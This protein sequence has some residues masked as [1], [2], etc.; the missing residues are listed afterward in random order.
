MFVKA[1]NYE[2]AI[3]KVRIELGTLLGLETDEEW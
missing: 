3:Q 1:K 2:S